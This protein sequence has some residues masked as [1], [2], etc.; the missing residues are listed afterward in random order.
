MNHKAQTKPFLSRHIISAAAIG[1]LFLTGCGTTSGL[2]TTQTLAGASARK[3]SKVSVRDFKVAVSEHAE[4]AASSA[5][6][7]PDLIATEIRKSRRFS[8]VVRN[9]VPDS[10]TL[11]IDGIVTK[12]DEGS[13]SKRIF[14]GMGFGMSFLEATV[15]FRDGKGNIIGTIKV[16]KNSWP[17]GGALAAGQNPHT[18]MNGAADKVAEEAAKLAR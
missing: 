14:L 16:D 18:F 13:T 12:Y 6:A 11:V 15:N 1:L 4:E 3:F 2:Q 5:V 9:G 8:S 7:F 17:L 10:N